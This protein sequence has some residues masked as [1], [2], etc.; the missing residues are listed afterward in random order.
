MKTAINAMRTAAY[1]K[2]ILRIPLSLPFMPVE[3]A[4]SAIL[5]GDI[6]LP[7]VAPAVLAAVSHTGFA[8]MS[9][10]VCF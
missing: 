7:M 9:S 6:I 1:F 10:A 5:R 3:T 8:P 2:V 4:A